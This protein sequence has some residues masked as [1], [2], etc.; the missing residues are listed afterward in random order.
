V[1]TLDLA[2]T[3]DVRQPTATGT[4]RIRVHLAG[5]RPRVTST[6]GLLRAAQ[7][8]ARPGWIRLGLVATT[9]LLLGGDEIE[10]NVEVGAGAR[11][12][13]FD[14]AGTVAYHGRGRPAG[15][16]VRVR[17]AEDAQLVWSGAPLVVAA[18]ADVTRSV[19]IDACSSAAALVRDTVVFGRTG[20]T[21]GRLR[22]TT[23]VT[24][25]GKPVYLEDCD[26]G[27]DQ[28]GR[29]GMLGEATVVDT[30]TA[31]GPAPTGGSASAV[32]AFVLPW[33]AGTLTRHLG[34]DLA[35]SPLLG[36]W[37][38]RTRQILDR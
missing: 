4:T 2:A 11:L 20:E 37:E 36:D 34:T 9:A 28:R 13:L 19:R 18:G 3:P 27:P 23:A 31:L 24:V 26:L 38:A 35:A 8:H 33:G 12:W 5:D 15:W 7:V 30:V 6:P 1:A 32:P 25:A 29:P 22:T 10:L 17:L 14:V 21:G 16:R